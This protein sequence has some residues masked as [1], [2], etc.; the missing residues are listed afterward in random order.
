MG[1]LLLVLAAVAGN[2]R[3]FWYSNRA[4]LGGNLPFFNF[5]GPKLWVAGSVPELGTYYYYRSSGMLSRAAL[6]ALNLAAV[7]LVTLRP[8]EEGGRSARVL[9][10]LTRWAAIAALGGAHGVAAGW[11]AST[12]QLADE[13]RSE[14]FAALTVL[15]EMPATL[16][17]YVYLAAL[18]HGWLKR[19]RLRTQLASVGV[20]GPL[21]V[22]ASFT[23]FV[24]AR[25][26]YP[27]RLS[28]PVLAA[29]AA[30]GVVMFALAVWASV[31]LL[32]LAAALVRDRV[33]VA[34]DRIGV[35]PGSEGTQ[36]RVSECPTVAASA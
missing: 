28:P 19:P 20:L 16:L 29:S 5:P 31:L 6:L 30:Y 23:A 21:L 3:L 17:I 9:R 12:R 24:L 33:L 18:A 35:E 13:Y 15:C 2:E 27:R 25:E 8:A 7:W 22:G 14:L 26:H 4:G 34:T 10:P 1:L 32:S 36:G 11:A